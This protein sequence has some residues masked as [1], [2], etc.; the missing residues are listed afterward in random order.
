M[1]DVGL[2]PYGLTYTLGLQGQG[3]PRANPNGRGLEAS[4]RSPRSSAPRR[5]RSSSP[6]WQ[7]DRR[8]ARRASRPSEASRHASGRQLRPAHGRHRQLPA[9]RA[10]ASARRSSASRSRRSSAATATPGARNGRSWSTNVR[11]KLADYAPKAAGTG[12]HARHREPPGFHQPRARRLL[13]RGGP[14]R[15]HRLR[16]REHAFRSPR[17]RSISRA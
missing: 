14:E 4:S 9:L 5:W 2:N 6:G 10:R 1:L 17:R 3:T 13:R 12:R 8:R 7:D 16:H 15:R 11:A